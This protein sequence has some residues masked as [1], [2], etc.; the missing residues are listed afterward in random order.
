[1]VAFEASAKQPGYPPMLISLGTWRQRAS[2]TQVVTQQFN[3]FFCAVE[4]L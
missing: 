4:L 3:Q 2:V 1:M